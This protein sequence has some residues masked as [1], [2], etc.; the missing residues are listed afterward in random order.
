[1]VGVMVGFKTETKG[2]IAII[3]NKETTM[4]KKKLDKY[5]VELG[6]NIRKLRRLRECT[7]VALAKQLNVSRTMVTYIESGERK[8]R[9]YAH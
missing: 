2:E 9:K 7:V 8:G 4:P 3:N 1:M 5:D 6:R